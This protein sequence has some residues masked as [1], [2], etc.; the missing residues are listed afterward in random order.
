MSIIKNL[1]S[2]KSKYESIIETAIKETN[3]NRPK[4]SDNTVLEGVLKKFSTRFFQPFYHSRSL[5]WIA[6]APEIAKIYVVDN[7]A[8]STEEYRTNTDNPIE[9]EYL[10]VANNIPYTAKME[11]KPH[12]DQFGAVMA[13]LEDGVLK[14]KYYVKS[15]Y[16]YPASNKLNST[17]ALDLSSSY[18]F[19]SEDERVRQV[20]YQLPDLKEMFIYKTFELMNIG[21][22]VHFLL[23][24]YIRDGLF[25]ATEDLC[26]KDKAF[27]VF[28]D[29][30]LSFEE[31]AQ[32]LNLIRSEQSKDFKT[33][34]L[35]QY[36]VIIDFLE[37]DTI[38]RLFKISDA[39]SGN[40]GFFKGDEEEKLF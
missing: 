23:N 19:S 14:K 40:F 16:G 22:K 2:N 18:K 27:I 11:K 7:T 26:S 39:N 24:Q 35:N 10:F 38:Y 21:P 31:S 12:G 34:E 4:A 20:E 30:E 25:I 33:T 9:C 37:I 28:G 15:Y 5:L 1:F 29:A 3:K 36:K 6:L 13:I 32:I 17:Q 8:I